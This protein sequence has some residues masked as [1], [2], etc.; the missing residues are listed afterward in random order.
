[1]INLL[2]YDFKRNATMLGAGAAILVLLQTALLMAGK[3]GGWG[4]LTVHSLLVLIFIMSVV[5]AYVTISITYRK[6]ITAYSRRLLP[7]PSIYTAITPI[8]LLLGIQLALAA[9]YCL[10][11]I[12]MSSWLGYETTL[13]QVAVDNLSFSEWLNLLFSMIWIT[14]VFTVFLF[15]CIT[16]SATTKSKGGVWLGI[17]AFFGIAYVITVVQNILF[18]DNYMDANP[19]FGFEITDAGSTISL[20]G[21][22]TINWLSVA[23]DGVFAGLMILG[24]SYLL[25]RKV[26][27]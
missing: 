19:N 4:F 7:L 3:W 1:M 23:Y 13:L 5:L 12:A 24:I 18:P 10:Y 25:N 2:K 14:I 21:L 15:F 8:L 26:K 17:I 16:L 27:V 22:E 6:N 20:G 9:M 11:D